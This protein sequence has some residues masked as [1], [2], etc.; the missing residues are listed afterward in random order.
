MEV[1][2]DNNSDSENRINKENR[3]L[4]ENSNKEVLRRCTK[5]VQEVFKNN[6][7]NYQTEFLDHNE[8]L[9]KRPVI[10]NANKIKIDLN[11]IAQL[12]QN[13]NSSQQ[14]QSERLSHRISPSKEMKK[15]M[16]TDNS[17]NVVN[18]KD[19]CEDK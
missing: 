19:E 6:N 12:K 8:F 15:K 7:I 2:I 1:E 14:P 18:L 10:D 16:I 3:V 13:N 17:S 5:P 11:N 4:S 9:I